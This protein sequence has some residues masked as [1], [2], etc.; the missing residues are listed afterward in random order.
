MDHTGSL[1]V[2]TGEYFL[3]FG[4]YGMLS[5]MPFRGQE[6]E[7]KSVISWKDCNLIIFVGD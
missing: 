6:S 1:W 2:G 4:F 7:E 3:V 5:T